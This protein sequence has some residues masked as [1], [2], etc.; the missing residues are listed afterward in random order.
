MK[1]IKFTIGLVW[2]NC[3][4]HPPEER[5]NDYLFLTDSAHVF[6]VVYS[7]L[8]GWYDIISASYVNID[9]HHYWAD[10]EQT[11]LGDERFKVN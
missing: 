7:A 10:I 11:V 2:H 6:P 9:S 8:F 3:L 4:E 5:H 1:N